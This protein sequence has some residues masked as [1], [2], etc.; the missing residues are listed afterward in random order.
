MVIHAHFFVPNAMACECARPGAEEI[1]MDQARASLLLCANRE[2]F[3]AIGNA[4]QRRISA[5][6]VAVL[7]VAD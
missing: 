1:Q 3:P 2:K 5:V 7:A 6:E 4:L